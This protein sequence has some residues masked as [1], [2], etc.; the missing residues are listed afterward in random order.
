MQNLGF[1]HPPRPFPSIPSYSNLLGTL[2]CLSRV[3]SLRWE[4]PGDHFPDD[5]I[6]KG[7]LFPFSYDPFLERG[8]FPFPREG[9]LA[10]FQEI[11]SQPLVS[12]MA[13]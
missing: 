4:F 1:S 8:V 5:F 6:S 9:L 13:L 7:S 2:L 11:F 12:L 10:L 3:F